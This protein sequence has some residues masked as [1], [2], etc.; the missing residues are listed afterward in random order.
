MKT[1]P[2]AKLLEPHSCRRKFGVW[3]CPAGAAIT[4]VRKD[5]STPFAEPGV[6][7]QPRAQSGPTKAVGPLRSDFRSLGELEGIFHIDTQVPHGVFDL[8]M[9]EQDLNRAEIARGLVDD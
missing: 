5:C 9:A 1:Q 7:T 2:P 6:F 8:G 3:F 4:S